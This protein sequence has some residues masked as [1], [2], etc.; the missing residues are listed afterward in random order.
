MGIPIRALEDA[1]T[2]AHLHQRHLL[3]YKMIVKWAEYCYKHTGRANHYAY[4]GK[5]LRVPAD[6]KEV[7]SMPAESVQS[8]KTDK[9]EDAMTEDAVIRHAM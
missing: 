8:V 2:D 3:L 4:E 6:V 7:A 1:P 9:I 5:W